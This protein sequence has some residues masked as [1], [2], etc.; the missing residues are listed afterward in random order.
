[1]AESRRLAAFMDGL[2]KEAGRVT[3]PHD[4]LRQR[5]AKHGLPWDAVLLT[6]L[7]WAAQHAAAAVMAHA[8]AEAQEAG[9]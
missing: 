4:P 5:M 3:Y 9:K 7:R 8:L 6:D 1:M 2:S